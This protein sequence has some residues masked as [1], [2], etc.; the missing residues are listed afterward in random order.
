MVNGHKV[1]I[2]AEPVPEGPIVFTTPDDIQ[3][4][5]RRLHE[6]GWR[7]YRVHTCPA[8]GRQQNLWR[9]NQ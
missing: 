5:D 9:G 1:R 3:L 2:D 7:R 6:N 8:T 4:Y